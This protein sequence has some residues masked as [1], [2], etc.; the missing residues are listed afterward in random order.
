MSS[1]T[2]STYTINLDA[3]AYSVNT[4]Y[5]VNSGYFTLSTGNAPYQNVVATPTYGYGTN[6]TDTYT[7]CPAD[8]FEVYQSMN[9]KDKETKKEE[10]KTTMESF[11]F[12]PITNDSIRLSMYGIAVKTKD[13]K[14]VSFDAARHKIIDVTDFVFTNKKILYYMPVAINDI[15]V[16]NA[17]IQ[18]NVVYYVTENPY[19]NGTIDCLDVATGE[20]KKIMLTTN[21]FGFDYVTK[22]VSITD[23][24]NVAPSA[25]QPFGNMLPLLMM[26]DNDKIDPAIFM[27]MSKNGNIDMNNPMLLYALS[28]GN[29]DLFPILFMMNQKKTD[30]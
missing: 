13:S 17:I 26:G 12:G 19:P 23:L 20:Y 4:S 27:L 28:S 15:A 5:D 21:M 10:E 22:I 30:K 1:T 9:K 2:A 16:G 3:A 8:I 14:W 18:N 25:D 7:I 11:K 24:Y 6:T 29:K